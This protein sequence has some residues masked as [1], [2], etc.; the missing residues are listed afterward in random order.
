MD[1]DL[2]IR[3]A[4]ADSMTA[5]VNAADG[6]DPQFFARLLESAALRLAAKGQKLDL[7]TLSTTCKARQPKAHHL[8]NRLPVR[9]LLGLS[10]T[11]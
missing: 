6:M 2:T 4:I 5:L 10:A 11:P 1:K 8:N 9:M 7:E 3:D